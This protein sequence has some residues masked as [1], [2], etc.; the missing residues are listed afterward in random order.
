[1]ATLLISL[2]ASAAASTPDYDHALT[3]DGR[4]LA[5]HGRAPAALLPAAGRGGGVVALVPA[6]RLSWH[7]IEL[8]RGIGARSPRLRAVCEGLLEERLLDEPE[9]LHLALAPGVAPGGSAWIAACDKA[10]LRGHLQALELAGR[11]AGR[12]VPEIFPKAGSLQ[13]HAMDGH[14]PQL[15]VVGEAADGVMLLPL[16]AAGLALLPAAAPGEDVKVF[17]EPGVALLAEELLRRGG[18]LQTRQQ[19]WLDA[20]RSPWDLAQF[21]FATTGRAR[22]ARRLSGL[23]QRLLKDPQWRLA[24]WGFAL[25][26]LVN[27]AGLNLAARQAGSALQAQRAAVQGLLTRTFPQVRVVVDAPLQMAREVAAL[28]RAAGAVDAR[29]F[30]AMLGAAMAALPANRLADAIEFSGGELRLKGL[31][32]SPQELSQL[33][34]RLRERGY[35]GSAQGDTLLITRDKTQEKTP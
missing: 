33:S 11:P 8:P 31:K 5:R 16:T 27:L 10:W 25:L 7:A 28:R 22:T 30:D 32:P 13:L 21:D 20:L 9:S 3:R 12:I 34:L 14:P 1:M 24:R 15:A 23:G 26:L 6:A 29:D 17:A 4:A 19:R 2:P 18:G 35:L